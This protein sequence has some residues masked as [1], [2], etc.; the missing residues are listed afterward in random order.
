MQYSY[1]QSCSRSAK[2]VHSY[3]HIH[4]ISD[5]RLKIHWNKKIILEQTNK[6]Q[7][8]THCQEDQDWSLAPKN[9][10]LWICASIMPLQFSYLQSSCNQVFYNLKRILVQESYKYLWNHLCWKTLV[11]AQS[12]GYFYSTFLKINI[13]Q[14]NFWIQASTKTSFW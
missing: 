8:Y 5:F 3:L 12:R 11:C 1:N 4:I 9:T 2:K 13:L 6:Q 14:S 7:M 10:S